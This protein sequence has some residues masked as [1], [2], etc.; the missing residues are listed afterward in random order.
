[1]NGEHQG[2]IVLRLSLEEAEKLRLV[3]AWPASIAERVKELY[4]EFAVD[5]EDLG[6]FLADLEDVL[7]DLN[8]AEHDYAGGTIETKL[9]PEQQAELDQAYGVGLHPGDDDMN[10][11]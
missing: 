8:V 7:V 3:A 1:M 9:D 6:N 4:P 10:E 2:E 5:H 11:I